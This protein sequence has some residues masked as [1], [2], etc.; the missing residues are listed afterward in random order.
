MGIVLGGQAAA[1]A[2]IASEAEIVSEEFHHHADADWGGLRLAEAEAPEPTALTARLAGFL[3]DTRFERPTLVMDLNAVADRYSLLANALGS[4]KIHYAVKANPAPALLSRLAKA[5]SNFDVASRG[6]IEQ[7]LALGIPACR[8]SFG[9]TIKRRADIE[10]AYAAGVPLFAFD[11]PAELKKLADAAPNAS[12]Y[13]RVLVDGTGSEWPLGKKFGCADGL[14]EELLVQAAEL[15]FKRPGISFHVGSQQTDLNAW[16]RC[17]ARIRA[18]IDRLAARGVDIGLVNLGGGFPATLIRSA[19]LDPKTYAETVR[20]LADRHF[21]DLDVA[22]I[23]EPGRGLVADAGC[24]AAEVVLVS[25]KGDGDPRR[26]VFLDIGKF[27]GLAETMDE[28]IRYR[29]ETPDNTGPMGPVVLAG[30]SCDSADVLYEKTEYGLPMTLQEGDRIWILSTGAYTT[31]YS[32]VGFN[33]FPPLD[34]IC[35]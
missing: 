1:E 7:C 17:F 12:V 35:I 27:S 33:G 15:G 19:K 6:E 21:G 26:W 30:P 22:L 10:F 18:L 23:A 13:C 3:A 5:G 2:A 32:S 29:F 9:N 16:D 24:I 8:L 28:A 14:A 20:H 34:T 25:E 11:S 31:T 4:A